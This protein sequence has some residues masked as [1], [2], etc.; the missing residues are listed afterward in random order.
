MKKIMLFLIGVTLLSGCK[1]D[2]PE[3]PTES[4]SNTTGYGSYGQYQVTFFNNNFSGSPI[5]VS[6]NSTGGTI[7][8]AYSYDPGC[9]ALGCANFTIPYGTYT[10]SWMS[11][12]GNLV[13]GTL[14]TGASQCI[15]IL[16]N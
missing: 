4:N 2:I 15:T 9:G 14:I 16:I 12:S 11:N 10:Y 7:T 5:Y 13:S 3:P 6:I 1:K 8:Y